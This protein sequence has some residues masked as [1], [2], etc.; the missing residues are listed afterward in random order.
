M[1]TGLVQHW[2]ACKIS[3]HTSLA[4]RDPDVLL[5]K[6]S[7][8]QFLLTRPSRDVTQGGEILDPDTEF[9]L[10]RPSRDVTAY[11]KQQE[12][13]SEFLLTRPSRDVTQ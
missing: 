6:E 9:L 1:T 11:R 3:T 4:G 7:G 5:R 13:L 8:F 12:V 2:L 10:T